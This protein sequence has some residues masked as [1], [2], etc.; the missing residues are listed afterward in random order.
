MLYSTTG[1]VLSRYP[2]ERL[3]SIE[4]VDQGPMRSMARALS[5]TLGGKSNEKTAIYGPITYICGPVIRVSCAVPPP[6]FGA[7]VCPID[8]SPWLWAGRRA[9]IGV[10]AG[11]QAFSRRWLACFR[12]ILVG[13]VFRWF[14]VGGGLRLLAGIW[15]CFRA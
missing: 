10:G 7:C 6:R 13:R 15:R 8:Y 12:W 3:E 2:P 14:G 9:P 1:V 11:P 5:V 4:K